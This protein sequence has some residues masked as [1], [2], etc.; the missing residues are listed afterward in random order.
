MPTP[1]LIPEIISAAID[2]YGAQKIR[3]DDKIAELRTMLDGGA[4]PTAATPEF[5]GIHSGFS[6]LRGGDQ[7]WPGL[8][9][10]GVS[11]TR[12]YESR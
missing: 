5:G 7:R 11:G 10:A 2:G 8:V 1:R 12:S 4:K 3:I 6:G 9:A